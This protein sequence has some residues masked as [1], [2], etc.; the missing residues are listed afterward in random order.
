M[1]SLHHHSTSA[2]SLPSFRESRREALPKPA[3][4]ERRSGSGRQAGHVTSPWEQKGAVRG[5][6]ATGRRPGCKLQAW[7]HEERHRQGI[8]QG[9]VEERRK[10]RHR[11]IV[12][13]I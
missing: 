8:T 6:K 13:R 3:E 7:S 9:A 10:R 2:S 12:F 4:R 1:F 5:S 11:K